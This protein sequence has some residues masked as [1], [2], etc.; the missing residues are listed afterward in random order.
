MKQNLIRVIVVLA[1][2]QL[3]FALATVELVSTTPAQGSTVQVLPSEVHLTMSEA[4]DLHLSRFRVYGFQIKPDARPHQV[5][6]AFFAGDLLDLPI[7]GFTEAETDLLSTES[8]N[9]IVIG[10]KENLPAGTYV[11]TW[12]TYSP[13]FKFKKGFTF[14][15]YSPEGAIEHQEERMEHHEPAM[16]HDDHHEM[17]PEE[18]HHDM[19]EPEYQH[20]EHME[21]PEHDHSEMHDDHHEMEPEEEH[22][23]MMEPEYHDEGHEHK[24]D[25]DE[26]ME[27]QEHDHSADHYDDHHEMEH[28]EE[29]HDMMEPEHYDEEHKHE[30][31]HDHSHDEGD[32]HNHDHMEM[33]ATGANVFQVGER[34][35]MLEPLLDISGLFKLALS[36]AESAYI[37]MSV[38]SPSGTERFMAIESNRAVFELGSFEEGIWKVLATVGEEGDWL[39]TA[40]LAQKQKSD[41]DSEVVLF[42]TPAPNLAYGG[43]TEVFVYGFANGDNLHK[44]FVLERNMQGVMTSLDGVNI[45]L[46]HNHFMD[47]Y[48]EEGFTP[49]A[50]NAS[51]D[52][53]LPGWWNI[54]ITIMGG[55]SET[56]TFQ[57]EVPNQ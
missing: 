48:N 43:R 35:I 54:L 18:E 45:D 57:I 13:D 44:R 2:F 9:N 6:R 3:V 8:G 36:T 16:E 7:I 28:E 15:V 20:D 17:K 40:I 24:D 5:A 41:F 38:T 31:E 1:I 12:Q 34:M 49:M 52:F 56:A 30:E 32:S 19:M 11:V 50:N 29:H 55:F 46:P 42:L 26:H 14:F 51:I 25:H 21:A 27:A 4:V 10:L 22:H 33:A 53:S 39:E 47:I 37:Q 23:D